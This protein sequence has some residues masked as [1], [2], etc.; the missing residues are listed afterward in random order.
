MEREGVHDVYL[1]HVR[2]GQT[3]NTRGGIPVKLVCR[4]CLIEFPLKTFDE[5]QAV[6]LLTCGGGG[7][8][9]LVGTS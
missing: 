5:V 7:T 4:K 6:Q 1:P 3:G 9:R 2:P 8:H